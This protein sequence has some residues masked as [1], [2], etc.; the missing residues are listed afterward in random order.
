MIPEHMADEP[1]FDPKWYDE[2]PCQDCKELLYRYKMD[3]V[4]RWRHAATHSEFCLPHLRA[5]AHTDDR[6]CYR[7][8]D[9]HIN[10]HMG[11]VLR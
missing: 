1:N 3:T 5:H 10:P 11:C 7:C 9:H 4:V 6:C 8:P 2:P